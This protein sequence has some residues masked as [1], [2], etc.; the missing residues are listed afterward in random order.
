MS[1][2]RNKIWILFGLWVLLLMGCGRGIIY[3]RYIKIDNFVWNFNKKIEFK[4][5]IKETDKKYEVLLHI[6]NASQYPYSNIWINVSGVDPNGK[7]IFTRKY[8][9]TLADESGRWLGKGLGDII[10]NQFIIVEDFSAEKTGTY[11]FIVNHEMRVDN[12]PGIMDI[13]LT[14][15]EKKNKD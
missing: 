10:D 14:V 15:R 13:G 6:R 3:T 1:I 11:S 2:F 5:N 9:F 4:V 7:N 8:E 12:V